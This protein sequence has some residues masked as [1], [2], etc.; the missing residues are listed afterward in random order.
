MC[1]YHW[2]MKKCKPNKKQSLLAARHM[3]ACKFIW[4]LVSHMTV[5]LLC[6]LFKFKHGMGALT[7]TPTSII[8]TT[9]MIPTSMLKKTKERKTA[10]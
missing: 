3:G 5:R 10:L 6:S 9:T 4:M 2:L 8:T 7:T 1:V